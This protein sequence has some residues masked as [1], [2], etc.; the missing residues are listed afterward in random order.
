MVLPAQNMNNLAFRSM[1]EREKLS[2]SNFNDWFRQLSIVL[3]VEKKLDVLEQ[4]MTPAPAPNTPNA[5]WEAWNAQYDRH[6]EVA[7]PMLDSMSLELQRQFENYILYYMLQE[8]KSMK[9][10]MHNM[11][12]TIGELHA[13]LIEYEK[14]L[15]NKAA[16]PRV[17]AIQVATRSGREDLQISENVGLRPSHFSSDAVKIR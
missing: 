16:T 9:Y 13:L 8:L 3:Q 14:G 2:R 17:L 7:C 15:P 6:N 5:G 4:P 11:G 10:N 1:L 12:K